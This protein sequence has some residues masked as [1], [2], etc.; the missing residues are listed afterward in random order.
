MNMRLNQDGVYETR[1]G[2][3]RLNSTALGSG[4][5]VTSIYDYRRP[6]GSGYTRHIL[7]TCGQYLYEYN[8]STNTGTL[9]RELLSDTRPSWVTFGNTVGGSVAIMANGSDFLTYD[10]FAV[11]DITFAYDD[12]QVDVEFLAASGWTSTNWTGAFATGWTH[13]TAQTSVLSFSTAAAIGTT[14]YI[15]WE[16]AGCTAGS[17]TIAFG[18]ETKTGIETTNTLKTTAT[19]TGNL[20]ITPTANFDGTIVISVKP[21]VLNA[22]ISSPRYLMVYDDRVLS[23]GSDDYPYR[24]YV[25]NTFDG[26]D[27]NYGDPD[28][29]H[30]WLMSGASGD[31]ITGLG[32]MY[33]YGVILQQFGI[34]IITGADPDDTA[35]SQIKVSHDYG[36]TSHW[37]IQ[38]VGNIIYFAD[39]SF[40]YRGV[41]REAIDNGM[42]VEPISRHIQKKYGAIKSVGDI[43]S[44]YDPTFE[45][46]QWGCDTGIGATRKDTILAYSVGLSGAQSTQASGNYRDVWAGWYEGFDPHCL[47]IVL[48]ADDKPVIW[49]GDS[50]GFLYKMYESRQY[51]DESYAGVSVD[52]D[53][54]LVSAPYAPN[55]I[56]TEKRM[57]TITPIA[58]QRFDSS[59]KLQW[60][61][62]GSYIKPSTARAIS[63]YNRV[64]YWRDTTDTQ[65][66]QLWNSTVWN[67]RP[68]VIRPVTV[69]EPFRYIQLRLTSTGTNAQDET[70]YAGAEVLYQVHGLKH[71]QG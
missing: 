65:R 14:Y 27:W 12:P 41:L 26:T 52:V 13:T 71:T 62:D 15:S 8:E 24:V 68:Y 53:T 5:A 63:L 59:L 61:I 56:S 57:K 18:G 6:D 40:V 4:A 70:T 66:A 28:V 43:V 1:R 22:V 10:G 47:A 60:I 64:P 23:A 35:T 17:F 36:T 19:T 20:Q 32:Q 9:L 42:M 11:T 16:V 21:V 25:S 49:R 58:F 45:E 48:D 29:G 67:S 7:V 44:V 54:E 38:T 39:E 69:D 37:S 34:S 30:Y 50:R 3:N 33:D 2:S 51:K 55:G 31:R 46:I